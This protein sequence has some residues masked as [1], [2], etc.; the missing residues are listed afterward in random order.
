MNIFIASESF[1]VR[2][3]LENIFKELIYSPQILLTSDFSNIDI[4]DIV[5][6]DFLFVD[7]KEN[8]QNQMKLIKDAKIKFPNLR[9]MILDRNNDKIIFEKAVE[10]GIEGYIIGFTERDEFIFTLKKVLQG[11]KVY[12]S[13]LVQSVL[14]YNR[15]QNITGLTKREREVLIEIGKGLNNKQISNNLYITE[16]TVK[17][18]VSNI[19]SKLNLKNR[20]EAILYIINNP[21]LIRY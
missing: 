18:H 8:W 13:E 20:Q 12:E 5:D 11:K 19:L 15:K 2:E 3:S 9:V 7:I 16:Y 21:L 14:S 1:I 4:N 10:L 6:L 17:K